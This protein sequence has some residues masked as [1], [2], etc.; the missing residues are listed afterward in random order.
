MVRTSYYAPISRKRCELH[1]EQKDIFFSLVDYR[2]NL[3][4]SSDPNKIIEFCDGFENTDQL[5]QWMK[6]R[7]KGAAYLREVE[8]DKDIVVVIPTAD[9]NGNNATECKENIFKGLHMIFVESGE[10]PDFYFNGAHNVNLGLKNAL[11]YNPKWILFSND[12]MYKID[13]PSTLLIELKK[14]GHNADILLT[15][16]GTYHSIKM[17]ICR[18]NIV[19]RVLQMVIPKVSLTLLSNRLRLLIL[20]RKLNVDYDVRFN[21]FSIWNLFFRKVGEFVNV[22]SFCIFNKEFVEKMGGMIYDETFINGAEDIDLSFR[23][24]NGGLK[25]SK[26]NYKIGDFIGSSLNRGGTRPFREVCNHLYLGKKMREYGV[27]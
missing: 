20:A 7:P 10:I 1:S 8:G 23:I 21:N 14:Q 27:L 16:T 24:K 2:N 3:L 26:I 17:N 18:L 22:G 12:D 5:I 19:G 11:K 9:F 4:M 15:N 25:I 13:E 6:E